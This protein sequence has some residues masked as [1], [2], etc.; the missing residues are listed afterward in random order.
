MIGDAGDFTS[1]LEA[2]LP[3]GWFPPEP[4]S[5]PFSNISGAVAGYADV[6]AFIYSLIT[7]AKAQ[8]R[9]KSATGGNLDLIANDYFGAALRRQSGQSDASFIT[10]IIAAILRQRNTRAA[11]TSVLVATTGRT[12]VIFNP[13]RDGAYLGETA[14]YGITSYGSR[15]TP[16]QVFVIAYRGGG[17]TDAQIYAAVDSVTEAGTKAWVQIQN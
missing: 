1:R 5:A 2:L 6:F 9:I 17:A 13:R 16:F 15:G 12:P 10:T 3:G 8:T 11:I 14:Y 7:Y 4:S